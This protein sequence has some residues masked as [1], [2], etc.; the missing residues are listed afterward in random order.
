MKPS[1]LDVGCGHLPWG[2][3][4]VDINVGKNKHLKY[5]YDVKTILNFTLAS[6]TLLPFIDNCFDIVTANHLIEHLPHPL[7]A[8]QELKR[9]SKHLVII[10]VPNNK[11]IWKEP[12]LHLYSWSPDSL[13]NLLK[14]EFTRINI[15]TNTP[16]HMIK[17]STINRIINQL[18]IFKKPIQR[19]L[20]R[21][22]GLEI[23]AICYKEK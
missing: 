16:V 7:Y 2:T 14:L 15:Y 19:I 8:L 6:A 4:N 11:G 12:G 1:T 3:V 18:P 13:N 21:L 20:S 22:L 17:N 5:D 10:K 23:T 9:V